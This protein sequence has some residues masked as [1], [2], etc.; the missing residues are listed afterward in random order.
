[1]HFLNRVGENSSPAKK[2]WEL[3]FNVVLHTLWFWIPKS[4]QNSPKNHPRSPQ[5]VPFLQPSGYFPRLTIFLL[6][7]LP[8]LKKILDSGSESESDIL[9]LGTWVQKIFRVLM[10]YFYQYHFINLNFSYLRVQI[11][12]RTILTIK[13][14]IRNDADIFLATICNIKNVLTANFLFPH[15]LRFQRESWLE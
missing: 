9:I 3:K 14:N 2:S 7:P 13:S 1:M 4:L 6:C 15:F 5:K 11:G 10:I 12:S 8:N